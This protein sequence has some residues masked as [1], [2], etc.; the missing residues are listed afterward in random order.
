MSDY[1]SETP[2]DSPLFPAAPAVRS[3]PTSLA[4]AQSL[5][6]ETLNAL[7]RRVYEFL[8]ATEAGSTDEEMQRALR[9]NPS[10]QRP[11][12]IELTRQRLVV[13]AGTRMTARGRSAVVSK[14]VKR[15]AS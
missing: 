3:S 13:E 4:A 9:M 5:T 6:P 12:R 15:S 11:R 2:I 1:Y 7:Q 14:A 8:L 10:T